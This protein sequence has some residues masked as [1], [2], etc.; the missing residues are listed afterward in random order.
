MS[1][2]VRI[3]VAVTGDDRA[4]QVLRQLAGQV[5][6]VGAAGQ[7]AAAGGL[8]E[9][10]AEFGQLGAEMQR[11]ERVASASSLD[12]YTKGI[13][14]Q[15]QQQA[16]AALSEMGDRFAGV[17][18]GAKKATGAAVRFDDSAK[19]FAVGLLGLLNPQLG[20]MGSLAVDGAKGL[21]GLS[22][23]LGGMVAAGAGIG[24]IVAIV[25]ALSEEAA[26]ARR[27]V[28]DLAAAQRELREAG[29][30][31]RLNLGEQLAGAGVYGVG[32]RERALEDLAFLQSAQGGRVP[33]D[34]AEFAVVALATQE[35]SG[36]GAP[37]R[38]T[39]LRSLAAGY[40]A[41]GRSASLGGDQSANRSMV[42][43]L[44][45]AGQTEA[46]QAA[47]GAY[48]SMMQEA[49][50]SGA[51]AGFELERDQF[52]ARL[53]E[54]A[55][56]AGLSGTDE[57]MILSLRDYT[58]ATGR[59]VGD[60]DTV[61][62]VFGERWGF[63]DELERFFAA[64]G[65]PPDQ[66]L[67]SSLSHVSRES[68]RGSTRTIGELVRMYSDLAAGGDEAPLSSGTVVVNDNRTVTHVASQYNLRELPAAPPPETPEDLFSVE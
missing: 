58:R 59:G 36:R 61:K 46:A 7:R 55:K 1:S 60:L 67:P 8:K 10:R 4:Q 54:H 34:A 38:A 2:G 66:P 35:A 23:A 31:T 17:A 40:V 33:T 57:R 24:A 28:L 5:G 64:T 20:Q 52:G 50:I 47:L 32:A 25:R 12:M 51:P 39:A 15:Q 45:A 49:T 14:P 48:A 29:Q 13:T 6:D 68:V 18:A 43:G 44:L 42:D 22:L 3:P 62:A 26:A 41:G 65:T 9:L 21:G 63:A 27:R 53:A 56:R 19:T 37:D 30:E 16:K 11:L